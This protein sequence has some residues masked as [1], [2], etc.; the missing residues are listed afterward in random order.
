MPELAKVIDDYLEAT[1]TLDPVAASDLG[2]HDHD[3]ELGVFD[4]DRMAEHRDHLVATIA[5]LRAIDP[6]GLSQLEALDHTIALSEAEV[7]LR[8][9]DD[10]RVWERAPYWYAERLGDALSTL[11]TRTSTPL[12][13]RGEAMRARLRATP[14]YLATALA[15]LSDAT[16]EVYVGM[17]RT[18]ARGMQEFLAD[19]VPAFAAQLPDPLAAE[20]AADSAAA[21]AALERFDR[22]LEDLGARAAGEYR[23]GAA[24][25]DFLLETYHRVEMDHDEL[26]AWGREAVDRDRA[27]LEALAAELDPT[28][29]WMEQIARVKDHHPAPEAF[30]TA[31]G[32]EMAL[33]REHCIEKDLITIPDGEVCRMRWL[34]AY[35]RASLPIAVMATTPPFE[36]GL[37]S[38]WLIT[39]LDPDAP[40]ERQRQHMRD[41]CYAFCRSIAGHEIYP[42]HHLQKVHHKLA[43][44]A[45]PIRRYTSSPLFV[46]G[47]GLYTEDLLTETGLLAEPD[48]RLFKLRNAL[49]RS[50]RVVVDTG[51]HTRG[52]NVREAADVLEREVCL[53]RHMAEGEIMRY[54]RHDNPT[55]PSSYLLGRTAIHEL[56]Q[57]AIPGKS[58]GPD[59]KAFHDKLLSYGSIPVA[60]IAEQFALDGLIPPA[61]G[62]LPG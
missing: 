41:N 57:R 35:L 28:S 48:V 10:Q 40:Q 33:A 15:T 61:T 32:D 12:E 29:S 54:V 25:V 16:P 34:P 2:V 13:A 5:A 43:T 49:W 9:H 8:R 30:V 23:A 36:P 44:A 51:L 21:G 37:E 4:A 42:G 27:A 6:A 11:M 18:A 24:H 31:Y 14:R 1:F 52:M 53:D 46:E 55:Y 20:I 26:Y 7:D 56:R 3:H 22:G 19:A 39:P 17:G 60:L 62:T 50:A 45:S 58:V 47:W 38:E 59:L